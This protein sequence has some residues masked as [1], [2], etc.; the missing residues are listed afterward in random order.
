MVPTS[1]CITYRDSLFRG[2]LYRDSYIG[3]PYIGDPYI[4][5]PYIGNPYIGD[6][7]IGNPYIGNPYIFCR[8]PSGRSRPL[9]GTIE[10]IGISYINSAR[11][12]EYY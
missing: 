1:F 4:G 3:I 9:L 6:P 8:H 7:Y 10:Y 5:I 2:S 11:I 12:T